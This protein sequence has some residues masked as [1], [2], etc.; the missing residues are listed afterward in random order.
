MGC[1]RVALSSGVLGFIERHLTLEC[2]ALLLV[3][4]A[5]MFN[6]QQYLLALPKSPLGS[7]INWDI[8]KSFLR[9]TV[10]LNEKHLSKC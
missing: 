4:S 3:W 9:F 5:A 1:Q 10:S 2:G 8:Y 7:S 6:P